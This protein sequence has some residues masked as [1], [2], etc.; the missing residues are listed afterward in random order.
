MQIS[1][2]PG[3]FS[4]LSM[5]VHVSYIYGARHPLTCAEHCDVLSLLVPFISHTARLVASTPSKTSSSVAANGS[6]RVVA[7]PILLVVVADRTAAA[8]LSTRVQEVGCSYVIREH[9]TLYLSALYMPWTQICRGLG[10]QTDV[11]H[12]GIP[13]A[14]TVMIL[15]CWHLDH[16]SMCAQLNCKSPRAQCTCSSPRL[17]GKHHVDVVHFLLSHF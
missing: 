11:A 4:K 1:C 5:G 10:I 2:R 13:I 17:L 16:L 6:K 14:G 7:T 3:S 8:M 9:A 15:P 12:G